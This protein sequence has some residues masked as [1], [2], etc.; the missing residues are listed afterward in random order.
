MVVA[1]VTRTND[2]A[3]KCIIFYESD[4]KKRTKIT[5][6]VEIGREM[7]PDRQDIYVLR[8]ICFYCRYAEVRLKRVQRYPANRTAVEGTKET[9]P[10][11]GD[12]KAR[13]KPMQKVVLIKS[14][15][16]LQRNLLITVIPCFGYLVQGVRVLHRHLQPF[17][18]PFNIQH[19]PSPCWS[20]MT[21]L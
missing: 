15:S 10:G 5:A 11:L 21:R 2:V 20:L 16:L 8:I 3:S 19:T 14:T 7:L 9:W 6:Q 4:S 18:L 12:K 17:F 13:I 1:W